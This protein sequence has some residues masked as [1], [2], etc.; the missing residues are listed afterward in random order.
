MPVFHCENEIENHH[1]HLPSP[2]EIE[3]MNPFLQE[4][5]LECLFERMVKNE[6]GNVEENDSCVCV[7]K[8]AENEKNNLLFYHPVL[9][10]N[11]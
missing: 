8:T 4:Q 3:N 5:Q 7:M 10:E 6:I 11:V 9:S 2:L 1:S